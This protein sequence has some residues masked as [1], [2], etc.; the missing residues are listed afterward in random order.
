MN[1]PW[2]EDLPDIPESYAVALR[3][4]AYTERKLSKNPETAVAYENIKKRGYITKLQDDKEIEK[5][6]Y[7]PH[8][9]IVRMDKTTTKTRI[10][11]D[12]SAKCNGLSLNDFIHQGPKLQNDLFS[13]LLRFRKIPIALVCDIEEMYLRIELNKK[14]RPFHRFLWRNM[15]QGKDPDV[16]EFNR[17]VFGVNTSPF[18]AQLVC[19]EHAR[20]FQKEFP[21]ASETVLE[22][23]YMDDSLDSTPDEASAIELY[24]QLSSLWQGA[25]MRARKWISN[26][27]RV[28]EQIPLID[29]ASQITVE[30]SPLPH[31][32]TLGITWFADTDILTYKSDHSE[33]R[34]CTKRVLLKVIGSVF[35]PL[36]FLCLVT[37][38]GK[39]LM[40]ELW[41]SGLDW[42]DTMNEELTSRAHMWMTELSNIS[43]ITVPRSLC[44]I[45]EKVVK[46]E[47][48]TFVD[49]SKDCYAN[50]VSCRLFTAKTRVAP[51]KAISI[52][53]LELMAAVL[54]VRLTKKVCET[55]NT[56]MTEVV[57]WSDSM[58]VLFWIKGNSR[59][60]KTFVANRI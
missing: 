30:D 43:N 5:K 60:W 38:H 18:L 56:P 7:L 44:K 40:Q 48:Y 49:A 46:I 33:K 59:R 32:K 51:L 50:S 22:S 23:A 3:R 25:H 42:D 4:L 47:I 13:V 19:Q 15:D 12:A 14:D 8:F 27:K 54:G 17:L 41:L 45:D 39:I 31:I 21:N 24:Q 34:N 28:L 35:D 55:L 9:S 11:F 29:R 58:N 16:F 37:I 1:I 6:W 57:F 20:K 10:V 36:G 26:S 53:R 52:P 2:K